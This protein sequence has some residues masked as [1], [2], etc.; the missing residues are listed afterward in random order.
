MKKKKIV[1]ILQNFKM[2]GAEKNIINFANELSKKNYTTYIICLSDI[3]ILKKNINSSVKI[4]NL[5][6]KRLLFSLLI[7]INTLKNLKVN[8]V[9]S[10]L[11]HINLALCFLKYFRLIK[12]QIILRPSNIINSPRKN[13]FSIKKILLF[14]IS[15]IF[16]NEANLFFS[17]S[18]DIKKELNQ[19]KINKI[20]LKFIFF[21][22]YRTC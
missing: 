13:A 1:F 4:I 6:K 18:T 17:I 16:L 21:F 9:F 20:L 15:K 12:T 7:I 10:S 2:G 3:G 19:L 22:K 5:N 8:Y 14:K 11:I